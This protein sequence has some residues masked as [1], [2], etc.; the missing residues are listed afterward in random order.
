MRLPPFLLDEWLERFKAAPIRHD[1]ASST[2]PAWTLRE[3]LSLATEDERTAILE[4]PLLYCPA[5]GEEELRA[6]I[7]ALHGVSAEDVIHRPRR[8]RLVPESASG[9]RARRT[10]SGRGR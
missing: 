8:V 10:S 3:L 1:L 2:G 5:A 4:R 9:G 6:G 7:A